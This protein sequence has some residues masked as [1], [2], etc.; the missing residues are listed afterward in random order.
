MAPTGK[1][2]TKK[3][4]GKTRLVFYDNIWNNIELTVVCRRYV[5]AM[6]F[7]P[8]EMTK[9]GSLLIL[10]FL[11]ILESLS[12]TAGKEIDFRSKWSVKKLITFLSR[13]KET[14]AV[15]NWL[16]KMI[17]RLRLNLRKQIANFFQ[18]LR[19][20]GR[21]RMWIIYNRMRSRYWFCINFKG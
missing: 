11:R 13:G 17:L 8:K 16:Q 19:F 2:L 9:S 7:V 21:N 1:K 14:M 3:H 15:E 5:V 6:F 20:M 12:S 10:D 4:S 18:T